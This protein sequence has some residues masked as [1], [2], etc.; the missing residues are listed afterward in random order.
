MRL[1][2]PRWVMVTIALGFVLAGPSSLFGA[3]KKADAAAPPA[4]IDVEGMGWW[5]NRKLRQALEL[6]RPEDQPQTRLGAVFVEDASVILQAS[7]QRDGFLQNSGSVT[8][9]DGSEVLG[10]F[11][12]SAG[13]LPEVPRTLE[14]DAAT[15]HLE[16]GVR[17]YFDEISFEGLSAIK[18][19]AA[20]AYFAS[21]GFLLERR[22]ARRFTPAL[23]RQG[24]AN[25]REALVRLGFA[26][27]Q[28]EVRGQQRDD[29]RGAVKVAIGVEEGPLHRV[30]AIEIAGETPGAIAEKLQ[31]I[32]RDARGQRY[33]RVWQQE[34]EQQVHGV[35]FDSGYAS[36][37]T[38]IEAQP[39][40]RDEGVI[41]RDFRLTITPGP[42]VHVASVDF[43][44]STDV[45]RGV[46]LRAVQTEPGARFDR[47]RIEADRL[48]LSALG[49]FSAV[50]A[51][52]HRE[53]P[54]RWSVTYR[55]TRGQRLEASL[56]AGYGS[57]EQ[58]RAG[59][60]VSH[61][62]AFGRAHRGRL[63][64]V[65]SMKSTS[66]DYLYTLPQIF[67]TT[68][69]ASA[70][71]FGLRREEVSFDR[72][73]F[74]ASVG[75]R[76]HIDFL[77]ADAALRYQFESADADVPA[78]VSPIDAR[79]DSRVASLTLDLTRDRRD[80]PLSPR[81]GNF[82]GLTH[83]MAAT[84]I[85]GQVNYQRLEFSASWHKPIGGERYVHVGLSHGV[86][87]SLDE[88]EEDLP[89]G[90][91]F[92][93][94]GEGN[95]RGYREGRAGPRGPDGRLIG[96]EVSSVLNFELEQALTR[97]LS[98][99]VFVDGGLTA[100][101]FSD[102]PGN[103][104]RVSAGLGLRYDTVIGPARLEYGHNVVREAGDQ[105]GE[106]HLSLG[107]PF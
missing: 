99:V 19:D 49:V 22:S 80:N 58:L 107:Y 28:V 42:E 73:E 14:G 44:G 72:K 71:V 37:R 57:Y 97:Q 64:L 82:L 89:L 27:A 6:L 34:F 103:E 74:G 30:G 77:G 78:G 41:R 56:L 67:G 53:T 35:L 33:S 21:E 31:Q 55:L 10:E 75:V 63:L 101:S 25:L 94:G 61:S 51:E 91:R 85:G 96:A 16:P 17:Y 18:P 11:P 65:Q 8:V 100:A 5:R 76:Q 15:F 9:R 84:A 106:I 39:P 36:A 69:D 2:V 52:V 12:W 38:A 83:E 13:G 81:R 43:A 24:V 29:A 20:R 59:V 86:L 105:V 98:A 48:R 60:E 102:Y 46:L 79:T 54:D 88:G 4:E 87:W 68:A 40:A 104:L 70:R 93:P 95:V 45:E 66:G 92:F 1:P 7:L 32:A 3:D 50:R 23:L 90:R 47:S 62:N 26:E